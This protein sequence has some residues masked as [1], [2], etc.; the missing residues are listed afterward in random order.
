MFLLRK[1]S[2]L[3]IIINFSS[4]NMVVL[5]CKYAAISAKIYVYIPALEL[6]LDNYVLI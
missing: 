5:M 2:I 4:F 6:E 3:K 1:L